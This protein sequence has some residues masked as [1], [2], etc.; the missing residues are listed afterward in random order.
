MRIERADRQPHAP[1]WAVA[2]VIAYLSLVG[3]YAWAEWATG[4]PAPS[5]CVFR[6][7]TGHPC[8]TCGSTHMVLALAHG[9][10]RQAIGYNP[11][12]FAVAVLLSAQLG[13]RLILRR[14]IVWITSARSRRTVVAGL[15]LAVL[16]NWLYALAVS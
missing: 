12:M 2:V 9:D 16:V 13:V 1:R 6:R 3:V 5:V 10:L 8:P 4:V 15:L 14:R 7:I 11:L